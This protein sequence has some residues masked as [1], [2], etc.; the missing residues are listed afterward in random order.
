[1]TRS[2]TLL[3]EWVGKPI[4]TEN[5]VTNLEEPFKETYRFTSKQHPSQSKYLEAIETDLLNL[6][7]SLK[8]TIKEDI[9]QIKSSRDV[10]IFAD[11]TNNL[12]KSSPVECKKLLFNN[13]TKSY[14]KS[15]KCLEKVIN[16]EGKQ[17]SKK[18]STTESNALQKIPHVYH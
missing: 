4:F 14:Q 6:A 13:L 15:T 10:S 2:K 17:I 16:M 18:K 1:M 3:K 5:K 11:K 7:N 9:A 12:Y 8:Q